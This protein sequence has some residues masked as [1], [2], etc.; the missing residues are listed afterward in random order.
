MPNRPSYP[1]L[2]PCIAELLR[3]SVHP[4]SLL[5]RLET[6]T[7][8]S[9]DRDEHGAGNGKEE[10]GNEAYLLW[11]TDREFMIQ[12]VLEQPLHRI[13]ETEQCA[14]GSLLDIKRFR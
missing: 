12:A 1:R 9:L 10:S 11:L 6:V 2:R 5:L 7:I 4:D 3:T 14:L 8:L 13:F